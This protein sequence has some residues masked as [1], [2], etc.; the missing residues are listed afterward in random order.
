MLNTQGAPTT[1][2]APTASNTHDQI[3]TVSAAEL[4]FM[5]TCPRTEKNTLVY[6]DSRRVASWFE[7]LARPGIYKAPEEFFVEC[8]SCGHYHRYYTIW[9][10]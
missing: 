10:R 5:H 1:P 8:A 9:I 3:L 2:H 6:L 7:R 4:A